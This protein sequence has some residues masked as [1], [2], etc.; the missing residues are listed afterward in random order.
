M[1]ARTRRM[2]LA[3]CVMILFFGAAAHADI[4]LSELIVELQP[5]KQMRDDIE[6]FNSSPERAYVA[7]EP[8]EIENPG[9]GTETARTDPDPE[10]LGLLVTPTRMV[11]EPGQRKLVRVAMLDAPSDRERVFR[12]TVKPVVGALDAHDTGLKILVGYDVLVLVRPAV[13]APSVQGIRSGRTL[14]FTNSGN[15][16]VELA[17]GRQCDVARAHC[18]DL[19]GKRLY[20]GA[21]WTEPLSSDLP[22]EYTLKG[23]GQEVRRTF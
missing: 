11:L 13:S 3:A 5:G 19:P 10:K 18:V 14:T 6:V 2:A 4:L 12:V 16:S 23:P 20:A 1:I 17:D 22:V 9:R 7:I 15:A 21:T 8:R